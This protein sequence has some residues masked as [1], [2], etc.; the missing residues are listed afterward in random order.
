MCLMTVNSYW[1]NLLPARQY[2]KTGDNIFAGMELPGMIKKNVSLHMHSSS[3]L[4]SIGGNNYQ[5]LIIKP[6][7][8]LPV[9]AKPGMLDLQFKLFGL[10]PIHHMLVDVVSPVK[11]IPGGQSIGVLLHSEGVMVVG[12]AAID[13][14]GKKIF[15][16]REA[17]ISVGDL[18][19][20]LNGKEVTGENQL[21]NLIDKCGRQGKDV[22]LLVK[23]GNEVKNLRINP[24][25]CDETGRYRVGLFVKDSAAGVGTITFYDPDSRVYGALGHIITDYSGK[26]IINPRD[27]KIVEASIK[28]LHPGKKGEPGE[29]LGVFKGKS[30]IIGDIS[31]NTKYGIFGEL[32]KGLKNPIYGKPVAVALTYQVKRGPA[33]IL[34]V[35]DDNKIQSFDIEIAQVLPGNQSKGLVLQVTDPELIQRTGGIIQGM[36]GSPILQDGK[37]VGA[38]THVFINDPTRGYGVLAENMLKE[39]N[40]INIE[41]LQ[42]KAG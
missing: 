40:L 34:T 15:P 27:G 29:K 2:I 10:I 14:G 38:V 32:E 16:A 12:E 41:Q 33:Q 17:G 13:Q 23:H 6:G 5:D 9:A 26:S 18:I 39:A 22:N 19:L 1:H 11:V 30:D 8:A 37:L 3:N 36:S 31:K 21:Q 20:K 7:S 25:L 28:G 42:K 35:L 4:L 24:I